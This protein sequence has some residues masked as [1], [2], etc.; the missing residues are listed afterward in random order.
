MLAEDRTA[1]NLADQVIR[2]GTDFDGTERAPMRVEEAGVT[3]GVFAARQKD[4]ERAIYEG[5]RALSGRRKSPL[6]ASSRTYV[7]R[8][9]ECT[10][11]GKLCRIG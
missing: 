7:Q 4:L 8:R 11:N 2:P 6:S 5:D 9:P 3:Y 10:M 1:E